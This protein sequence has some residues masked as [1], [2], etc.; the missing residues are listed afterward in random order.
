MEISMQSTVTE[1]PGRCQTDL[2]VIRWMKPTTL[3]RDCRGSLTTIVGEFRSTDIRT[4]G[5]LHAHHSSR[6]C[7]RPAPRR[8]PTVATARPGSAPACARTTTHGLHPIAARPLARARCEQFA[9]RRH[10][11]AALVR[12][13]RHTGSDGGLPFPGQLVDDPAALRQQRSG[14]P[15]SGWRARDQRRALPRGRLRLSARGICPSESQQRPGCNADQLLRGRASG[16]LRADPG[17]NV[18]ARKTDSP[19]RHQRDALGACQRFSTDQSWIR[20]ASKAAAR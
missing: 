7:R 20:S 18:Q 2:S 6:R 1:P 5:G 16:V 4:P 15:R 9:A 19:P 14:I 10:R 12:C 17:G 8:C 11:H 13:Q 3:D